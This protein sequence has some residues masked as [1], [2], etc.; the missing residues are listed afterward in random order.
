MCIIAYVI[1]VLVVLNSLLFIWYE[2]SS[3]FE[4]FVL[5]K[6]GLKGYIKITFIVI[7]LSFISQSSKISFCVI[8]HNKSRFNIHYL[9]G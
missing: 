8:F 6:H 5:Q 7:L 3:L 4:M 2:S 9:K 1:V